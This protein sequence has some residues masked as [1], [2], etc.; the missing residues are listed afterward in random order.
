M[1]KKKKYKRTNNYSFRDL[2]ISYPF[3]LFKSLFI[4]SLTKLN[5]NKTKQIIYK[6]IKFEIKRFQDLDHRLP[7]F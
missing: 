1:A 6:E 2:K 5:K 3:F 7:V 4:F